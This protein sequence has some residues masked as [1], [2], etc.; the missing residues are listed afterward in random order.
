MQDAV[1]MKVFVLTHDH[2]SMVSRVGPDCTI[3]GRRE[4]YF[5]DVDGTRVQVNERPDKARR[6]IL[7]EK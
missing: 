4:A 3:G 2:E 5:A 6:E 1:P 7:V